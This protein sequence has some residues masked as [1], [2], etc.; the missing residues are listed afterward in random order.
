L[1]Q[2]P[3]RIAGPVAQ[4]KKPRVMPPPG[5]WD[6]QHGLVVQGNARGYDNRVV[7]HHCRVRLGHA[8][9][10]LQVLTDRRQSYA[11]LQRDM[12]VIGDYCGMV[13]AAR[14]VN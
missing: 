9:L 8:D 3:P 14:S 11:R 1:A 13:E 7:R 5:A 2:E 10:R 4:P 6:W 12:P